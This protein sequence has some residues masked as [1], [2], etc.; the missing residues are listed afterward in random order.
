MTRMCLVVLRYPTAETK[1]S[2]AWYGSSC[3]VLNK[4]FDS[5]REKLPSRIDRT[6]GRTIYYGHCSCSWRTIYLA[7]VVVVGGPYIMA[8][9][10]VVGGPYIWP[11]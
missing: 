11:L 5:K 2:C 4:T 6:G 7:T 8:T 10:V 3:S 9:V 1:S